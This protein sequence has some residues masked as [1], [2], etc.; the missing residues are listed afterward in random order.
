MV[1]G[2][3]YNHVYGYLC[4]YSYLWDL[5]ITDGSIK[6]NIF[7]AMLNRMNILGI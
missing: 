5:T 2:D 1:D 7:M 3:M 4:A 6:P